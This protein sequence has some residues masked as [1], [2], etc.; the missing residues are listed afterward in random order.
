MRA[1]QQFTPPN[2]D[3]ASARSLSISIADLPN[4]ELS[5]LTGGVDRV[6]QPLRLRLEP[7]LTADPDSRS[8]LPTFD[9][10][11]TG[12]AGEVANAKE[13]TQQFLHAGLCALVPLCEVRLFLSSHFL[14]PGERQS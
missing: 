9:E 5:K 11:V 8:A 6:A 12:I 7:G 13:Q 10:C 14:N 1:R 2:A 3:S 4:L